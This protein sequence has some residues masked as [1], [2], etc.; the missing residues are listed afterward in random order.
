MESSFD[1]LPEVEKMKPSVYL[2]HK[3]FPESKEHMPGDEG[4]MKVH[5][6][7]KSHRRE[8]D[9]KGETQYEIHKIENDGD[10]PKKKKNAASMGISE[11]RDKITKK[12]E[13]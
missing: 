12:D 10:K 5:Y 11:L 2:D 6:K 4:T 9:G 3:D 1:K 13:E 7:V 8:D